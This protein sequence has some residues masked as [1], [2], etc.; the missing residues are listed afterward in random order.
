MAFT[1]LPINT[2]SG[3]VGRQ[4]PSKRLTSEAENID[5]CLVTLEKSVE[6]R[7]P[8]SMVASASSTC[9]LGLPYVVPALNNL[10][11]DNLYFHFLDI[12]GFNRYCIIINRA[13]YT[14]DP[15]QKKT[16]TW[17]NTTIN[18]NNFIKVFRIE[19]TQWIEETVDTNAAT[20]GFNRSIFDYLTFGNKNVTSEYKIAN[21]SV[22]NVAVTSIQNTFGSIDFDVGCILWNKLI[23]TGYL[24]NNSEQELNYTAGAAITS[25]ANNLGTNEF[26]HSG[27]IIN[28]KITTVPGTLV[29]PNEDLVDDAAYIRNVRDDINLDLGTFEEVEEFGQSVNDFSIIPQFPV[30]EVKNDVEDFNG[31][32]AWRTLHDLYDNPRLISAYEKLGANGLSGTLSNGTNNITAVTAVG[33][34][35]GMYIRDV[36]G[37][38]RLVTSINGSTITVDGPTFT[39]SAAISNKTFGWI[40]WAKDHYCIT[41]SLDKVDRDGSTSY[42]GR[43]K[44][45]F[46]R[47]PYLTFPAGFYKAT[48]YLK[49]PYFERLRA[50]SEKSVIDF[51]RM[52]IIIFKD[53][54]DAGKWKVRHMPLQPRR[55]GTNISNP[56]LTGIN[57]EEKI[58]SMAIWKNRLWMA[59]DNNVAASRSGAYFNFWLDD[60]SN[61]VETDPID[62]GASVGAYNKLSHILPFQNILVVLSS[63]SVQFEIRGGSIDVGIS[64]FNTEFRPTSFFSTS[65]LTAPQKLGN[66]IF[67]MNA[68][69]MYMYLSGSSFNDEYSTSMEVSSHCRGYLPENVGAITVSSA[70]NTLMAVDADAQ[71]KIYLFTF[72]TNGEKIV[73]QAFHRWALSSRDQIKAMKSYEKDLYI[74]SRRPLTDTETT[75]DLAVYFTSLET[76]PIA[77]PMVDWLV[78]VTPQPNLVSG[79]TH[80]VLPYYDPEVKYAI[81]APEWGN[82]AYLTFN[83]S[84]NDIFVSSGVTNVYISGDYRAYPIYVGRPYE[85]N[86]ELSQQVQRSTSGG[87]KSEQV[88]EGVL[89]LKRLTTRH[90]YT[91]SYDIV[92][93]RRGRLDSPVTFYPL[94]INSIVT[95]TD[96]LK[97]DTV[98]E[99]FVKVLSYSESCRIFIKSAYPTPCNISNIELIGNFRSRNSSIE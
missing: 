53:T 86:I 24:P 52:P 50:E 37:T 18:L 5:N 78:K 45:Y 73:Q 47:T 67:F 54:N 97:V 16:F 31:F 95:R 57:K 62:I 77:T 13:G 93:E 87:T 11:T 20:S 59:T 17:N 36:D 4:A 72:R 90:L 51:R 79:K 83:I 69:R 32:R 3:G 81:L 35:N 38:D 70:V 49:N 64:P 19:P 99:H 58:Q 96:L 40:D 6:K 74:I 88:L 48:R 22:S 91:G 61:V 33:L 85:M 7:P 23:P 2:L 21:T 92:I 42:L 8:L 76:V 56:G 68:S 94:D 9:Y 29:P 30:S 44:V 28:Y 10:N 43:G 41:S 15:T 14:F 71:N 63:G 98:G 75:F 60:V 39:S 82:D 89:N 1:R 12:D 26:I 84:A 55:A 80:L 25:W 27:D 65:K 46:A 66:N 34:Q